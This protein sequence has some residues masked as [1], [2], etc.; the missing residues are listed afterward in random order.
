VFGKKLCTGSPNNRGH[1]AVE[2]FTNLAGLS[3]PKRSGMRLKI[4]CFGL[5]LVKRKEMGRAE[6]KVHETRAV[7]GKML[8][9]GSPNGRRHRAVKL[10]TDSA[11]LPRPKRSVLG[12]K[13]VGNWRRTQNMGEPRPRWTNQGPRS[14][15]K[16]VH[17]LSK[18]W[19]AS[20]GQT[21]CQLSVIAAA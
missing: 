8:C 9:T 21:I 18:W 17:G 14:A 4:V 19:K 1:R 20:S 3:P 13:T 2:L 6:A 16:I 7:F 15:K 12:L 11:C 5:L 10:F